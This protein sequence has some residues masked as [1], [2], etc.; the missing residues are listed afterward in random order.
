MFRSGTQPGEVLPRLL[1]GGLLLI[2]TGCSMPSLEDPPNA[3]VLPPAAN[4]TVARSELP[5]VNP[6]QPPLAGTQ[7]AAQVSPSIQPAPAVAAGAKADS[8]AAAAVTSQAV[9]SAPDSLEEVDKAGIAMAEPAPREVPDGAYEAVYSTLEGIEV[10]SGDGNLCV[11]RKLGTQGKLKIGMVLPVACSDDQLGDVKII[12][13]TGEST[14]LAT[15][16]LGKSAPQSL[17]VTI[18]E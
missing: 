11:G 17:P 10:Y 13:L 18:E 2:L 6:Q 8:S 12:K 5:P 1:S 9:P 4:L 3:L 16:K 14:A 15:L 7:A